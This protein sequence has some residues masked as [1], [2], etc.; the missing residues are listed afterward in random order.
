MIAYGA[1][2]RLTWHSARS[3]RSCP[4]HRWLVDD[5]ATAEL[6]ARSPARPRRDAGRAPAVR[7]DAALL[8]HTRQRPASRIL[9]RHNGLALLKAT[10]L[11]SGRSDFSPAS[12]LSF[13]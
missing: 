8:Y 7:H 2:P 12:W 4:L 1:A 11:P 13:P 3:R 9:V 5:A 10:A 6:P